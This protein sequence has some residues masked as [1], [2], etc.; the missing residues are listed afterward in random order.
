MSNLKQYIESKLLELTTAECPR[1]LECGD[2]DAWFA[3]NTNA[4]KDH[5]Y[6][7]SALNHKWSEIPTDQHK[8]VEEDLREAAQNLVFDIRFILEEEIATT[9]SQNQ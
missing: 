5:K 2:Q 3:G 7:L 9:M 8:F 6:M 4:I 1:E